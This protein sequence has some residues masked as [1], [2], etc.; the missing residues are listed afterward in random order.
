MNEEDEMENNMDIE[1]DIEI[2]KEMAIEE[3]IEMDNEVD[4]EV[5]NEDEQEI[6]PEPGTEAV[7]C[8]DKESY[9]TI[10]RFH[11]EA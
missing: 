7:K 11:I 1:E 6:F 2:D 8:F 10:E 3:A 9:V 4:I 5:N